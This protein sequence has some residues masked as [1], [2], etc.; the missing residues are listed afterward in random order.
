MHEQQIIDTIL[1]KLDTENCQIKCISLTADEK[2]LIDRLTKD[3]A[4]GI[5]SADIID[6]S[7][8]RIQMY[9]ILD[10]IKIDTNGKTIQT[11]SDEI[12]AL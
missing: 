5:R 1:E 4:S 2:N 6:K 10:T 9:Q 7:I 8:A 3:V 11:I 12:R